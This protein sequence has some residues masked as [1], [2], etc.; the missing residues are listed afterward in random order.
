MVLDPLFERSYPPW[1]LDVQIRVLLF[2]HD[3]RFQGDSRT[4]ELGKSIRYAT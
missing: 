1:T 4:E 2:G 3:S